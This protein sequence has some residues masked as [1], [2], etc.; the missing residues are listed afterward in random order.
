MFYLVHCDT[1]EC[2]NFQA[3]I[4]ITDSKKIDLFLYKISIKMK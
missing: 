4:E 1:H 3:I 2:V